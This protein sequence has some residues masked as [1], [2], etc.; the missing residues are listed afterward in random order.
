MSFLAGLL[1]I[2]VGAG[3]P[4]SAGPPISPVL[5]ACLASGD[6]ARGVTIAMK[7]CTQDE[8]QRR[9]A[10]LNRTYGARMAHLSATGRA[11]LRTTQR[12]WIKHRDATCEPLMGPDTGSLGGLDYLDCMINQTIEQTHRL[13]NAR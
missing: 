3:A 8:L 12:A 2:L 13:A 9:D 1:A 7:M 5:E 6:A 10:V 11:R 4:P